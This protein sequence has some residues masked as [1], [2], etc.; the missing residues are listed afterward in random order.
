MM[1]AHTTNRI[2][3][4]FAD[5]HGIGGM[6]GRRPPWAGPEQHQA[7]LSDLGNSGSNQRCTRDGINVVSNF[8]RDGVRKVTAM[9]HVALRLLRSSHC[10]V[11]LRRTMTS[12]I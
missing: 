8:Q 9:R 2:E 5:F 6:T 11:A 10:S 4:V 7:L 12:K 3:F 1:P